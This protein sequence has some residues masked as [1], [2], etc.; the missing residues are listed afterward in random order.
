MS[1]RFE[2]VDELLD[3]YK[4]ESKN[5][6]TE[7]TKTTT[8]DSKE[9]ESKEEIEDEDLSDK[10]TKESES[11]EIDDSQNDDSK[12]DA[13][14]NDIVKKSEKKRGKKDKFTHQERADYAFTKLKNKHREKVDRLNNEINELKKNLEKYK[15][16]KKEDFKSED[17]FIDAKLNSRLDTRAI[18]EKQ[19]ELE[20]VRV[21]RNQAKIDHFYR[22]DDEKR[23]YKEVWQIG[24][25]NG[26]LEKIG[27]DKIITDF[28]L[29]SELSPKLLEH[30][31]LADG[32]LSKIINLDD[33]RKEFELYSLEKRLEAFLKNNNTIFN[34][35]KNSEATE[36][37]KLK[38]NTVKNK[39]PILGRNIQN[40]SS[41]KNIKDFSNDDDV[42]E[43]I[44][45]RR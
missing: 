26:I 43:F 30:F 19:A 42:F 9:E 35:P 11:K 44:R 40:N 14:K 45:S 20:R 15:L 17:D 3:E 5:E 23:R 37:R 38:R 6:S 22:T 24:S 18:D 31:I 34:K 12:N 25:E 10:S 36:R 32:A 16:M 2:S 27:S 29:D 28:I 21:E 7:N 13:K 8:E 33:R 1:R 41:S 4:N 39:N